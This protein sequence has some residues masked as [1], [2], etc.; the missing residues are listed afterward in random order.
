MNDYVDMADTVKNY[1]DTSYTVSAWINT[2]TIYGIHYIAMYRRS[3]LDIGYQILFHLDLIDSDV[4]FIVGSL[5]NNAI[6]SHPDAIT[7]NTWYH[8]AGVREENTVNVYVNGVSGIPD[9]ETFGAISPDNFKIGA[10]HC[11]DQG[12]QRFFDGTIDDV[13]IFD[14]ALSAQEI[15]QLYTNGSSGL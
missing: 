12:I 4:R 9:S 11:C 13:M 7:T 8:V 1:L 14:I 5:G 6:A 15:Q 3:T 10:I 2:K